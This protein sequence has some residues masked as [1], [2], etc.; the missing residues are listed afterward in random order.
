MQGYRRP[1]ALNQTKSGATLPGTALSAPWR[2]PTEPPCRRLG[3]VGAR[4]L[5]RGR[6]SAS[7]RTVLAPFRSE[8]HT[9]ELQSLMRI[10]YAVFRLKTK[11]NN[12]ENTTTSTS[13]HNDQNKHQVHDHTN[14]H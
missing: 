1:V 8:E 7:P 5:F 4:R 2:T 3:R 10:S 13:S 9:S 12:N 14:K 11:T 6:P